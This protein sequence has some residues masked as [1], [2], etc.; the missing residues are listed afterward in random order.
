MLLETLAISITVPA[1]ILSRPSFLPEALSLLLAQGIIIYAVHCLSHYLVGRL[2]GIRFS[3]LVVG[4]SALRNS[5]SRI[6]RLVGERA[7]TP[8]LIVD[9]VSL[10]K[11]G[12]SRRKAM[13]YAG[14][15]SSTATPFLVALYAALRRDMLATLVT[16]I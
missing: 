9:R 5:G 12:A 3:E 16:F 11:V 2:V 4:R 15:T 7:V 8:V 14:V 6:V 13:F 10:A 1:L